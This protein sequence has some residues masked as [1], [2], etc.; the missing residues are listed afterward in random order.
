MAVIV[1]AGVTDAAP[2][3]AKKEKKADPG[4]LGAHWWQLVSSL[5]SAVNPFVD[6]T[7]CG[8]GQ[9]GPVWFLY[10]TA[11]ILEAIGDP[12]DVTCTIPAG[13]SIFLS[14]NAAFCIPDSD[15]TMKDAVQLCAEGLDAP[16]GLR[17]ELD[18]VDYS[19]LIDRRT[20]PFP[21]TLPI[22][23]DNVYTG[24]PGSGVF[25]AV[26]DGY[27]AHLPPLTPGDHTILV[28]GAVVV[29]D[30]TTFAF[31]TRHLLHIVK[32]VPTLPVPVSDAP[33]VSR[34]QTRA[35]VWRLSGR[36]VR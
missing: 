32:P 12:T 35:T 11:P 19:R 6:E 22:P 15:E 25:S 31:S 29:D 4:G 2:Q 24:F 21:F 7:K 8:L 10:S 18:G 3:Q 26:H 17:L 28:Q 34:T 30:G 20:S 16:I 1:L 33:S 9:A 13:K 27:Y 14:V 36:M 5:P 23:E